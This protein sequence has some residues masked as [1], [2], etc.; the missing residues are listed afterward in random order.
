MESLLNL[1]KLPE[2]EEQLRAAVGKQSGAPTAHMYLGIVL[3][4][5]RKLD[6]GQKELGLAIASKSP[7]VPLAHRYLGGIYYENVSMKV[8]QTSWRLT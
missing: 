4:I 1:K 6:E 8:P 3:A 5:Q 7:E 2:A